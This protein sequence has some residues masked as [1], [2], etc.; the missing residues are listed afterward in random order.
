MSDADDTHEKKMKNALKKI[1]L[2]LILVGACVAIWRWASRDAETHEMTLY[3]NVDQRQVELAFIDPERIG[4]VLVE[5]GDVVRAGQVLA[6]QETRRLKD[7]I[8]VL[9]ADVKASEMALTRLRNGTRPEEIDR[10][11]AAV[12]AAEAEEVYARQQLERYEELWEKS[13][14]SISFKD[15]DEKRTQFRV[16]SEKLEQEG[17][18]L[19]LAVKGPRWEDIAEAEAALL[20]NKR[21]LDEYRNRL[22]DAELKAP[23]D[24]V[25]RSRLQEPGD[26]A[27]SQRPVFSLA[28]ISP[29]WV[30]AYVSETE[31]GLVKP[32]MEAEVYT[33]S[34]PG[35]AVKGKVGFISPVAE[36][37]PKTVQTT[38]LRTS[39]VYEIRVYV[40]DVD[41]RLRLGMPATV[42]FPGVKAREPLEE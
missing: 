3:G 4:E 12:A 7:R 23:A 31:L 24:A 29:K 36:F 15:V 14:N 16:A 2:I 40:E 6:R 18:T 21:T 35:E 34:H 9:E 5:E 1:V 42:V 28:V 39:L 22:I 37:T 11:R 27:S 30:R 10:A 20:L 25:V 13:K 32:G 38:E 19:A 8:A 26:M 33:D 41:D 17:K